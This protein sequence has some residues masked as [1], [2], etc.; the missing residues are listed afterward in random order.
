M[1]CQTYPD[2]IACLPS[3][4]FT[5]FDVRNGL[6]SMSMNNSIHYIN[7][8]TNFSQLK[9]HTNVIMNVHMLILQN[10][11]IS[12]GHLRVLALVICHRIEA[13]EAQRTEEPI[14]LHR[15]HIHQKYLW[16]GLCW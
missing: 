9:T 16:S 10:I 7:E 11:W 6:Q 1:N 4:D 13:N 8:Y 15:H 5:T 2:I 3:S 14:L 12:C